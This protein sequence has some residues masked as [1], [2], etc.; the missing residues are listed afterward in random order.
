MVKSF[1]RK[2]VDY[3]KQG[4]PFLAELNKPRSVQ[5]LFLFF[6]GFFFFFLGGVIVFCCFLFRVV[7]VVV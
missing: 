7:V 2:S 5:F 3:L 6:V 4:Q 1:Q